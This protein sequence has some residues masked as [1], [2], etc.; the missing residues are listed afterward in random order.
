[1]TGSP[2]DAFGC[3]KST[4]FAIVSPAIQVHEWCAYPPGKSRFEA[5][6]NVDFTGFVTNSGDIRLINVTISH[7]RPLLGAGLIDSNGFPLT[8]PLTLDP[9]QTVIFKGSYA[10]ASQEICAQSASSTVT[11]RGT[12]ITGI[13]GPRA[14][15]TNS[16]TTDAAISPF[17]PPAILSTPTCTADHQFRFN[18]EGKPGMQYV[19]Q[20]ATHPNSMDWVSIQTNTAPFTFVDTTAALCPVRFYRVLSLK[21]PCSAANAAAN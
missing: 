14:S 18:V 1:M 12:D 16:M 8:Q 9:G 3:V 11:V 10:P 13:G 4:S 21:I 5:A 2:P 17:G 15:V 7:S 19:V 20:A 6:Q